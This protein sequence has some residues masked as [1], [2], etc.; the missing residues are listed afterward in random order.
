MRKFVYLAAVNSFASILS[1]IIKTVVQLS[2]FNEYFSAFKE[3][4]SRGGANPRK[5]IVVR[6]AVCNST[7]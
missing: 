6:I 4:M 2:Q 3:Y 5:P 1:E 7:A